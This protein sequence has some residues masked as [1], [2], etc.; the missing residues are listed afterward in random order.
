MH[1]LVSDSVAL[2]VAYYPEYLREQRLEA[3]LDLMLDAG[4]SAIRVGESVW[5]TWE[6]S[7]GNFELDWLEPVLDAADVRGIR[8]ILGTPTYAVPMWL[9]QAHPEIAA[10]RAS[11]QRVP[12]GARQ[13]VETG[14]PI[15]R[16]YAERLIRA[17]VGRYAEHPAVIGFQVDNE[18]GE[19]LPHNDHVFAGFVDHLRVQYPDIDDLN[20]A[21]N[22]AHW[23]HRLTDH[24]QLWRPDGNHVPQ[25]DLEWR[26][27]QA[28]RTTEYI[29]WQKAIVA[30]YAR[31]RHFITTCVDRMRPGVDE[32]GLARATDTTSANLYVAMQSH[33][34][35]GRGGSPDFPP[36]GAW[37]P[38]YL[39]DRAWSMGARPFLVA[40]TNAGTIGHPW[41]NQPP[42]DGQWR[43]VA[44][45]M[46]ARGARAISYWN[47]H[48][49]HGSWEMYWHGLLPHSLEP[50][51]VYNNVAALGAELRGLGEHL[52]GLT[53][54]ATVALV[55]STD[56][57]WLWEF[58][59][60][61]PDGSQEPGKQGEPSRAAYEEL[62]YRVYAGA[63]RVGAQVRIVHD[64]DLEA[65]GAS[66][67]LERYPLVVAVSPVVASDALTSL[68]RTYVARGGHLVATPRSF[69][70]DETGCPRIERQPS[71][72]AHDAGL[73]VDE[74]TNIQQPVAVSGELEGAAE[75]LLEYV[76]PD[77]ADVI[78]AYADP[79]WRHW[80]AVTTRAVGEG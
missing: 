66:E 58:Q 40:E 42:H 8:A 5:S 73:R 11:G 2:G 35:A 43:S 46:I 53:P 31:P 64:T 45:A 77:G 48:S 27:Y 71:G 60:P 74:A 80:A 18:P 37:A 59:P 30:D 41:F 54:D 62:V 29:A 44:Y 16:T 19:H 69:A 33:I 36:S 47:W 51:R 26:R 24:A 32:R 65:M 3:D 20:A 63:Q 72:F 76:S 12:W 49:M 17:V 70:T 7:D 6:P 28:S 4:I 38:F 55:V 23:S 21:W 39:A 56:S 68:L 9:A 61:I 15:F 57:Q 50:G 75:Q 78:A 52:E 79:E 34:Q 67:L 14:H 22:L 10:E 1:P 25:Y 13:E